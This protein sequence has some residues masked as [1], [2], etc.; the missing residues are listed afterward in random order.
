MTPNKEQ[1]V[2]EVVDR[3]R[4]QLRQVSHKEL[5]EV[6]SSGCAALDRVL[7]AGGLVR[8]SLVE[9]LTSVAAGGATML[10]MRAAAAACGTRGA[11]VVIDRQ[12]VFYPPAAAAWGIDLRRLILVR[13]QS[14][15][16]EQWAVEQALRCRR[17]AAVVAWPRR[18]SSTVWRR[19]Q[20]A[21]ES[22]GSVGLLV[23]GAEFRREPSWADVRLLVHP[24]AGRCGWRLDVTVLRARG[25]MGGHR[26]EL[27]I[28]ER[29]GEM[30]EAVSGD[31]APSVA[32]AVSRQRSAGA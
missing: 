9:W 3:L 1:K 15:R 14:E 10:A 21:A 25:D 17:V 22:A 20:L 19:W 6:I 32:V 5:R 30:R 7:P 31:L 4:Q 28:D 24:R 13:P 12:G 11:V 27:Q 18:L 8:G 23:R 2:A 16:D 29:T 26:V